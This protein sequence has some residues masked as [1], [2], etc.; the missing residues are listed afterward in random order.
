MDEKQRE[1]WNAAVA[2]VEADPNPVNIARRDT[3][4]E[5]I[6]DGIHA[7]I[8]TEDQYQEQTH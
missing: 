6:L 3:V 5:E 2:A 1:A 7:N 8:M 4:R